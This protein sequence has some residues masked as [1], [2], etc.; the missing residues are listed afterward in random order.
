M[1]RRLLHVAKIVTVFGALL[2]IYNCSDNDDPIEGGEVSGERYLTIAGSMQGTTP[3]DGNGGMLV[4]SVSLADA[5]DASK[6]FNIFDN[7]FLVPSNR[8][9]RINASE[10]GKYIY[11]I[12]YTGD[13]G[14]ILTKLL[15][16]GGNKFAQE[17]NSVSIAAYATTSPRWGKL[18]N[19]T[20]V[21]SNIANF[22][23]GTLPGGTYNNTVGDATVVSFDLQ[24]PAIKAVQTHKIRLSAAEEALGHHIW[25]MDAPVINKAGNKIILGAWMRKMDP[26]T[27]LA[28]TGTYTRLGSK[29]IVYDYPSLTN[30]T[31]ITS[32]VG[33]GDTSGYRSM[34]SFLADDG[35]IYQATQRDSNGGHILRINQN[36]QYDNSYN[37]NLDSAL[38]ETNVS[39]DNWKYVGNGIAYMMYTSNNSQTSPLTT[40]DQ[41]FLARIDLNAKTATKVALPYDVDLYFFQFQHIALI[42]DELFIPIAPVGKNGNIY[43]INRTTGAITVGAK[44]KNLAGAQFIGAY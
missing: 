17:G 11:N 42:G 37:F 5:K 35:N 18:N 41:S 40:Q 8:T 34:N 38:G 19:S 39:V 2:S 15:V 36:N 43:I 10:D 21:A 4:Y 6:E 31:V 23:N 20:G 29:S 16:G 44:L 30:P 7:G 3:G 33:F 9:A 24:N 27:G 32:T 28:Q 26:S 1:K 14:G 25:R 12:P 22:V 13:N